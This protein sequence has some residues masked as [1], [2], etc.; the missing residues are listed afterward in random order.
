MVGALLPGLWQGFFWP[1]T[2]GNLGLLMI[3]LTPIPL[4]VMALGSILLLFRAGK[5]ALQIARSR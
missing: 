5:W 4:N 2:A 3:L 1:D